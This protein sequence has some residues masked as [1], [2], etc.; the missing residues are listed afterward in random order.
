M[1]INHELEKKVAELEKQLSEGDGLNLDEN[2][3]P[4][5]VKPLPHDDDIDKMTKPKIIDE[6]MKLQ[7]VAVDYEPVP[8]W[9]YSKRKVEDLKIILRELRTH[10]WIKQD[11][12]PTELAKPIKPIAPIAPVMAVQQKPESL[13]A[14]PGMTLKVKDNATGKSIRIIVN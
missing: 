6:L 7:E 12:E 5:E 9:G 3:T 1:D 10:D 11:E 4:Q 13:K 14:P 2:E 8:R